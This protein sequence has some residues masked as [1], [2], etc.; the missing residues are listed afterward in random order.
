MSITNYLSALDM[1]GPD[2]GVGIVD[3]DVGSVD[4]LSRGRGVQE[5]SRTPRPKPG[6]KRADHMVERS[7]AWIRGLMKALEVGSQKPQLWAPI[8][9][10]DSAVQRSYL[11]VLEEAAEVEKVG[12]IVIYENASVDAIPVDMHHIPLLALTEPRGP[13]DVLD[14]VALGIDLHT[15]PFITRA[16]EAGIAFTFKFPA[17]SNINENSDVSPLSLGID[18]WS[19]IHAQSVS[20]L[21]VSCTCYACTRHHRAYINHLLQAKEMLAWVLLQIHNHWMIDA[22]FAGIR[23]SIASDT[24]EVDVERW[25]RAYES[26]LPDFVGQGP[27]I[28][29]YQSSVSGP[30][31]K[32]KNKAPYTRLEKRSEMPERPN[33]RKEKL[34]EDGEGVILSEK[35]DAL[36]L[37]DIGFAKVFQE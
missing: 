24:F 35:V 14:A 28:R 4:E 8:L 31:P 16:T 32:K 10:L 6:R 37:E 27:R 11:E 7:Q 5:M 22:F 33:D 36:D 17:P 3:A 15:L 29:G 2:I 12:G 34:K 23:E 30:L 18:L 26:A 13:S 21:N 9:P 19:P 25:K 1:C 20:P